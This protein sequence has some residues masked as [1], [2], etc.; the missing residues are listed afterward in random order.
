[1]SFELQMLLEDLNPD[2]LHPLYI[3][4]GKEVN[5]VEYIKRYAKRLKERQDRGE[6]PQE[7]EKP[8]GVQ[9][10]LTYRCNQRC[11]QCYNRSGEPRPLEK[12][13]TIDQWLNIARELSEIGVFECIISGGEP[14]LLG[15][16]LY[17]I[18]DILSDHGV[19]FILITNG[20]LLD[21]EVIKRLAKYKYRFIQVSI[22][23]VKPEI[24]DK[25][26]GADGAWKRAIR[27]A[28]LVVEA[29]LPLCISH[30]LL[31]Q[32]VDSVGEMIDLA[33]VLGAQRIITGGYT[34]SGRAILNHDKI[35]LDKED[36]K[37][38][39]SIVRRK[40]DEYVYAGMEVAWSAD[41][42]MQVKMNVVIPDQVLLIRPNG[43]V[44]I[45]CETPI[46]I[47]NV[48]KQSIM[49]IW[50]TLGK[51]AWRNPVVQ[52]YVKAFKVPED[53]LTIKPRPYVDEEIW[54]RR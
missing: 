44:K 30:C 37:R 18:M 1:M 6:F 8:L 14:L 33:Y 42:V 36:E 9:L 7:F 22:D 25:I 43:D 15:D 20:M 12:E 51:N 46:K 5:A 48:L 40:T 34:Y 49:E 39:E 47:G 45:G 54:L 2:K 52:E 41:P 23:G 27:A 32:N 13:M 21:K 50:E 17:K 38:A 26:R 29:N 10:E 11:I 53:F 4:G 3:P 28:M 16:D 19:Y 31:K 24:H 35:K